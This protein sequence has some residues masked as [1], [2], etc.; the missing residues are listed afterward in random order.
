MAQNPEAI[1]RA[2]LSLLEPNARGRLRARGL[3]R[4]M[5]WRNGIV[6][7]GGPLF[8]PELSA[9]L[10]DYGY[11]VL[12]L[13]LELREA[14]RTREPER[15]SKTREALLA[16]AEALESAIR[17]GAS[18]NS[19]RGQHLVIAAAAFHLAGYAA[20]AYS[21]L[22][23]P[24]RGLNLSSPEK[25][26]ALLLRRQML[27]LRLHIIEWFRA[28]EHSD[29]V[30]ASRLES[31][32]DDFGPE[33]AAVVALA[34]SYHGAVG[35][36]DSALVYGHEATRTAALSRLEEIVRQSSAVGNIPMWWVAKL[37]HHLL[38]DLW[39]DSLTVRLPKGPER[40]L[41]AR[42]DDLRRDFIEVLG[43][44]RLP[45]LD[46]W[47]SQLEAASRAIDPTDDLI[48][49]LPTSAGKTRIAEMCILRT[50]ANAKRVVY[51]TPLRALSAEV[52]RTLS[53]TFVPLGASVTSLYGA[54]G[55]AAMD[56]KTLVSADVVVATPEKLDFALRQDP[57]VLDDVE[58]IVLD[59][60]HM[61][62]LGSREIRYEV[63]IQRLLR[64]ADAARRRIVCLSA[65]FNPDDQLFRDFSNWIRND[66][67][68]APIHVRWRPTRQLLATL[69]WQTSARIARLSFMEGEQPYVPRF[70]EEQPARGRR[71]APFPK[72]DK[73]LC[74]AAARAFANDG[75]NVLVYSPQRSQVESLVD[76]FCTVERQG[77]LDGLVPPAASELE[78][79]LATGREWL[80][81]GH[82][83]V[84]G[85]SIGVGTHHGS[86]PRPFLS[87]VENLLN[88][89]KLPIVVAS[90]TLA[91]G[92]DLKCSAL[93]FRSIQRFNRAAKRYTSIEPA[94]FGN[95][96]GRVG[97]AYVDIDGVAVYPIFAG[98]RQHA[99]HLSLFRDL[100][101]KSRQQRLVSG[102]ARLVMY[103]ATRLQARLSVPKDQF[104]E[105]VVNQ[106]GLWDDSRL[107][108]SQ[109][110]DDES[111]DGDRSLDA[112]LDDLDV[113][114]LSLL[115][116]G[117][118][119][120]DA[121]AAAL[122]E[123]LIDSLWKRTLAHTSESVQGVE[124]ELLLSRAEWVWRSTTSEQ[125]KACFS[126]GLGSRA[127][128]FLYER[129][130]E[131]VAIVAEMQSAI[132]DDDV[133]RTA[134]A[135]TSFALMAMG[136]H[137]FA[138][139]HPPADWQSVLESWIDGAAFAD[140]LEGRSVVERQRT[141][142]FVQD[143]VIFKLVW[144][145]EAVR[146][147]ATVRDHPR[148]A[149]LG[150]GPALV[151][152]H[153]VPSVRAALLCQSGFA[154]RTGAVWATKSLSGAFHDFSGMLSWQLRH[155]SE[156]SSPAFWQSHDQ[157]ILWKA[158]RSADYGGGPEKWQRLSLSVEPRW[159]ARAPAPGERVRLVPIDDTTAE[160]CTLGLSPL[161]VV[162]L[163]FDCEGCF[164]DGAIL[165]EQ[166][167]Q[168]EYFGPRLTS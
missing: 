151:L 152:T 162:E 88:R 68:G 128:V 92:I 54:A 52:E 86:L 33:D 82:A 138:I 31:E 94:E 55:V 160:V 24:T 103:I 6:P 25:C 73:E 99:M 145:V 91:Q 71:R 63:L 57:A 51:V 21:L 144:A 42:W 148:V 47:P 149:E 115:E 163:P 59:E 44:R 61:I 62:G 46:L 35:L 132:N 29:N 107:Q 97:R 114:L 131:L 146:A 23:E 39:D 65:M 129:L 120:A 5:V 66:E 150:D 134:T 102:L 142:L 40:G 79:A 36:F 125:R 8:A 72:D 58:L 159:T 113:A 34:A 93:V 9:D 2:L 76:Q 109:G 10:L 127:G 12:A 22:A 136:E 121:L 28:P 14:N 4:G 11:G 105:Y 41:S 124:R 165:S 13:A 70:T 116:E 154:S 74:I 156:L 83:A 140:I 133:A 106:R 60:G 37:T 166:R 153:G 48:V 75:H 1:E 69:D 78:L 32:D 137:F 104:F 119:P 26:L 130:D 27:T 56:A 85:L 38:A 158:S 147:Q 126:A 96:V 45:Q 77:Y 112:L 122:D 141:Q 15:D 139:D 67:P 161:A 157:Y 155:Q 108:T 111:D 20:R 53:R 89:R 3:A 135:A 19:D 84:R 98:G 18:S 49:A 7:E 64:R 164:L 87:A 167:V 110:A 30:I 95:V 117:D 81:S 123:V 17:R 100:I 16:A 43:T 101:D 80:G 143:A 50:L 168:I 90:P 118:V